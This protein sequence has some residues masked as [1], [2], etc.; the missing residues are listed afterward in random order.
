MNT[1]GTGVRVLR[2]KA[3]KILKNSCNSSSANSPP[4][5]TPR[6]WVGAQ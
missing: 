6:L 4:E 1:L 5:M 3:D 2:K